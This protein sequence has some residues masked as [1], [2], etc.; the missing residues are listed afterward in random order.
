[1]RYATMK[2]LISNILTIIIRYKY[3]FDIGITDCKWCLFYKTYNRNCVFNDDN[4]N[5]CNSSLAHISLN[6]QAE[7]WNKQNHVS[8]IVFWGMEPP[9]KEKQ[10]QRHF[11]LR[12][13]FVNSSCSLGRYNCD[14]E[15]IPDW[16]T[17]IVTEDV[18]IIAIII[19]NIYT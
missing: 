19:L 8:V 13:Y 4:N 3:L 17:Y 5:N 16:R 10:F 7:R 14:R 2:V 15:L 12:F 9:K 18:I 6:V 1:M 11:F